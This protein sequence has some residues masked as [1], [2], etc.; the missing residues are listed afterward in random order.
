M[1]KTNEKKIIFIFLTIISFITFIFFL[2]VH[3]IIVFDVDDWLYISDNRVAIPLWGSWNP[4]RVFPE[5]LAPLISNIAVH[6]IYPLCNNYI[7][8]LSIMNAII[9]TMFI[10]V[11]LYC[12]TR[13][14]KIKLKTNLFNTICL[15]LIFYLFHFLIFRINTSNNLYMFHAADAICYYYYLIP[16]L[17]NCSLVMYFIT[18]NTFNKENSI[19]KVSLILLLIYCAIFSNVFQSIILTVFAASQLIKPTIE[20]FKNINKNKIIN[21]IKSNKY[22]I[23]IISL[24]IISQIFELSGG[25]ANSLINNTPFITQLIKTTKRFIL[26]LRQFNRLFKIIILISLIIGIYN[27]IKDKIYKKAILYKLVF[28]LFSITLYL[29]LLC[30]ASM[31]SYI[32]RVDATFG[33]FFYLFILIMMVIG[34]NIKKHPQIAIL[35]PISI[36]ILFFKINT[37][38]RTFRESNV[39][40]IP[41][42]DCI[43]I[44]NIIINQ[45]KNHIKNNEKSAI[46]YIPKFET[47]DNWPYG[48]YGLDRIQNSLYKHGIIDKV[49]ELEYELSNEMYNYISYFNN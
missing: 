42:K 14:I 29:L 37:S 22:Q 40:G 39:I 38:S 25:R 30:S 27:I 34:Y 3:P 43:K 9:V 17:L 36:Y 13:M 4:T 33:I 15:T 1:N 45:I 21:Y 46:I 20:L 44:D 7:K 28:C 49:I 26:L 10:T 11:Y 24:W 35:F 5:T 32:E 18:D 23:I 31:P 41:P 8:S 2:R 16:S 48:V 12:F 19:V 47:E 6:L